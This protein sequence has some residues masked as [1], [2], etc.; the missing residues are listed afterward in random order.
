[1]ELNCPKCHGTMRQY[2]RSG[3]T[4]DQCDEC[5]GVYLDRGE[6]ERLLTAESTF[7]ASTQQQPPQQQ[8][9]FPQYQQHVPDG[10]TPASQPVYPNR[11]SWGSP[12]SPD[13]PRRVGPGHDQ[14]R[15]NRPRSFLDNLFG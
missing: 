5:R 1:M 9:G 2:E 15:N 10:H 3:I 6:L 7:Y 13:S 14:H 12:G 4:I 11:Q 8:P